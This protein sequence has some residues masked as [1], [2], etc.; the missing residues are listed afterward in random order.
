MLGVGMFEITTILVN[1]GVWVHTH[2][3]QKCSALKLRNE[4]PPRQLNLETESL[5]QTQYPHRNRRK[6]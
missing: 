2:G 1:G 4:H 5:Y 3:A 6:K